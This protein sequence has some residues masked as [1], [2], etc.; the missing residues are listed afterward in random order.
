MSTTNAMLGRATGIFTGGTGASNLVRRDALGRAAFEGIGILGDGTTYL[1]GD[2]SAFGPKNG[3]PG[4]AY[5]KFVPDH[6]FTGTGSITDLSQSPL[7]SGKVFGLRVG[8][9]KEGIESL[10]PWRG[11]EEGVPQARHVP[12]R[13]DKGSKTDRLAP[14]PEGAGRPWPLVPDEVCQPE[15]RVP[16]SDRG[17]G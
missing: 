17:A 5:Y 7:A 15:Q 10:L 14:L 6:P 3:G 13:C 9:S 4:N 12:G 16:G 1:D 8:L 2:D 11:L